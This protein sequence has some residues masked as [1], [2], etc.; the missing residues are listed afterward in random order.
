MS[1]TN[2][3]KSVT[4]LLCILILLILP[5]CTGPRENTDES[6]FGEKKQPDA[7]LAIDIDVSGSFADELEA[8]WQFCIRA[9]ELFF[10]NRQGTNDLLVISQISGSPQSILWSG[11]PQ[12]FRKTF[13]TPADFKR[14]FNGLDTTQSRVHSSLADTINH[15]ASLKP[16]RS[17]ILGLTDMIDNEPGS[18][19]KLQDA[20]R[21]YGKD[22]KAGAVGLYGVEPSHKAACETM[23]SIS[24]RHYDVLHKKEGE[25]RIPRLDD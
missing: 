1:A 10:F 6:P 16:K 17:L 23:L 2:F 11:S 18:L 9:V 15:V 4:C 3:A 7:V 12:Q 19:P 5:A 8:A 22:G 24:V 25:P 20:L 14:L 21:R 13:K